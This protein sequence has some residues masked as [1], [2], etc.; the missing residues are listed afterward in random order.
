MKPSEI[1]PTSIFKAR[2]EM[3]GQTVSI[4]YSPDQHW[5]YLSEQ[6]VIEATFIK[7]WDSKEDVAKS[8]P[9]FSNFP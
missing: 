2:Y 5:Y 4:N 7:I 6:R 3:Q 9:A 8:A 1:H